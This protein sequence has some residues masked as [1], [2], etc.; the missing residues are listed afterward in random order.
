VI[1]LS[2]K[3]AALEQSARSARR[4]MVASYVDFEAGTEKAEKVI[5]ALQTYAL[6]YSEYLRA[7]YEYNTQVKKLSVVSGE[8]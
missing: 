1:G 2:D 7:V 8:S 5:T 3:V 6:A 4:W